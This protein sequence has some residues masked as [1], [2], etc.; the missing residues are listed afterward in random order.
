MAAIRSKKNTIGEIVLVLTSIHLFQLKTRIS[1]VGTSIYDPCLQLSGTPG[2]AIGRPVLAGRLNN[3]AVQLTPLSITL[4]A[5][6]EI[7][8]EALTGWWILPSGGE[9]MLP[10]STNQLSAVRFGVSSASSCYLK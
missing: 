2:Y 9:C 8:G 10:M 4:D 1:D 5:D 6:R 3:D 7:S